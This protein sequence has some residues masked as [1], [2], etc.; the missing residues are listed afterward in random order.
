MGQHFG[1]GTA[2]MG[3]PQA[4]ENTMPRL[5][6]GGLQRLQQT[7]GRRRSPALQ[8]RQIGLSESIEIINGVN[9]AIL[10]QLL[11]ALTSKA[12]NV[13]GIPA[14]PVAESTTEDCWTTAIDTAGGGL[15]SGQRLEERRL[16]IG[17]TVQEMLIG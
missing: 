8:R 6:P 10:Y 12:V 15:Q 5:L 3:N 4:V 16:E 11:N 13:Q 2:H 7:S 17:A 9:Q 1:I 14:D